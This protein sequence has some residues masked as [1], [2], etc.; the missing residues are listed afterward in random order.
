MPAAPEPAAPRPTA[1]RVTW[2]ERLPRR[3]LCDVPWFGRAVVLSNGAVN[4][5][6]FSESVVGNVNEALLATIW[7]AAPMQRIRE[8]LVKQRFPKEC[9]SNSCPIFRGD[10]RSYLYDRMDGSHAAG[11]GTPKG[12]HVATRAA[13]ARSRLVASHTRVGPGERIVLR[14]VFESDLEWLDADLFVGIAMPDGTISFLPEWSAFPMPLI[15]RLVLCAKEGPRELTLLDLPIDG[16][17][18][19]GAYE[20]CAALFVRDASAAT[21]GNCYWA[22]SVRVTVAAAPTRD[23]P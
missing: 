3:P 14:A 8:A 11:V 9:Q 15:R 10:E 5:C 1:P 23:G 12:P 7:Q 20:I 16:A 22:G 19:A 6:C 13:L 18:A 2:I 17:V 4:F 21:I